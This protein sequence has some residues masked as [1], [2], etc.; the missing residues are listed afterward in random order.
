MIPQ[1]TVSTYTNPGKCFSSCESL[2]F[3]PLLCLGFFWPDSAHLRLDKTEKWISALSIST[4]NLAQEVEKL[5]MDIKDSVRTNFETAQCTEELFEVVQKLN[6]KVSHLC[7]DKIMIPDSKL[8][9]NNN[10]KSPPSN[11]STGLSSSSASHLKCCSPLQDSKS[12]NLTVCEDMFSRK[13]L[14]PADISCNVKSAATI[15]PTMNDSNSGLSAMQAIIKNL[16]I[17]YAQKLE[18]VRTEFKGVLKAREAVYLKDLVQLRM[19]ILRSFQLP[20]DLMKELT[21]DIDERYYDECGIL[22]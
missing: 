7:D 20:D 18:E 12:S 2:T 19:I 11:K 4:S 10:T 22:F 1:Q 6:L 9:M 21:K 16:E 3:L 5:S 17:E 13:P 8:G 14:V 15:T